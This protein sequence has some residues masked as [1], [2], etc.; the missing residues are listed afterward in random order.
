MYDNE[1]SRIAAQWQVVCEKAEHDGW[2]LH[3]DDK[4]VEITLPSGVIVKHP[5]PGFYEALGYVWGFCQGIRT[6]KSMPK[7]F[8][9]F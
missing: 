9:N 7:E 6:A 1:E 2:T 8:E 4:Y 5:V 3:L